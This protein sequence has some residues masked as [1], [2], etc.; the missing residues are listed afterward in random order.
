MKIEYTEDGARY[1]DMYGE[2]IHWGDTV[3]MNG[4]EELV[5]P[6]ESAK[7]LDGYLGTDATNPSW[8]ASGRAYRCQFGVYQFQPDDRPVII[9]RRL[10]GAN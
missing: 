4:R 6:I 10:D 7:R 8:I 3:L 1:F 9:K 5:Y 2:E